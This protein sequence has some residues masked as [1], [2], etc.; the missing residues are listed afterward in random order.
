MTVT[1]SLN[2]TLPGGTDSA[3]KTVQ[4]KL[5]YAPISQVDR[6]WR[7]TADN[8][9]KDKTC[10]H[11]IVSRPYVAAAAATEQSYE[12]LVQKD[13]PTAAYFVRAYALDADGVQVGYGQTTDHSK[14][15]NLFEVEGISG[16]HASLDIAASC[17]S[18]FSVLSLVGFFVAEK[19][20]GKRGIA[21]PPPTPM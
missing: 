14:E 6:A 18:A 1:W 8:L 2:T 9:A 13:V 15:T 20:R 10:Q 12:W 5:C 7:K 21:A 17:F 4:V 3:Y 16:R 11:L 19:R